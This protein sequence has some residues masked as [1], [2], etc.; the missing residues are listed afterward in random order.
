[1]KRMAGIIALAAAAGLGLA[2]G[3]A[4]LAAVPTV[5]HGQ[6]CKTADAG[7]TVTA[8]NGAKV[9]C[10]KYA[11]DGR[12]HWELASSVTPKTT[13]PSKA[14]STPSSTTGTTDPAQVGTAPQGGV[15][16]GDG[17]TATK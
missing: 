12:Y 17:S 14:T 1:M 2:G 6:Y 8:D 7:K 10:V 4:A 16:T 5:Q 9:T 13:T 11:S 3:G 15:S